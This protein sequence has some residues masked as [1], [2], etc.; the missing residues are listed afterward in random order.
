VGDQLIAA[1]ALIIALGADLAPEVIPGFQQYALNVYDRREIPRAAAALRGFRGGRLVIGI[2]GAPYKCPP[3]PYELALLVNDALKARGV[4]ANIELCTPQP[5]ALPVL[6]PAHSATVVQLLTNQGIAFLADHKATGVEAG[7]V[8]FGEERRPFDLLLGIP[9]H[10]AP[11]VLR[12]SGLVDASGWISA[13]PRTLETSFPG[14]YAVG[15]VVQ[16]T[17]PNGKPL[18]K[19]GIFAEAMGETAADR[20]A[21]NFTG[22][23]P[24]ATFRAEGG[25]YLEVGGG[26]AMMVKG[27]FLAAPEPEVSITEVGPQYMD[28]KRAFET[29][30]LQSWFG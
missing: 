21:A 1:D 11:A 18:P 2:F 29:E 10:R 13:D 4:D 6:G 7:Q 28:E 24:E 12:E 14:V 22:K 30:H 17:L 25:C 26:Q 3:G 20:I 19:A 15:D 9:P 27:N 23:E 16:I 5:I 8:V